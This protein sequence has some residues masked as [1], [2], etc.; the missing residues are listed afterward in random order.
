MQNDDKIELEELSRFLNRPDISIRDGRMLC[1]RAMI[2]RAP[3]NEW[4]A[5]IYRESTQHRKPHVHIY[6]HNKSE[7]CSMDFDGN[8]LVGQVPS[9][10]EDKSRFWLLDENMKGKEKAQ[11]TWNMLNPRH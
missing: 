10:I 3:N 8:V 5:Y 9:N 11:E 4:Q 1:T 7:S 6:N 2:Y